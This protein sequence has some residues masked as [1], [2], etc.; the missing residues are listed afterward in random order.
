MSSQS[1]FKFRNTSNTVGSRTL[2]GEDYEWFEWTIYMDEPKEKLDLVDAVEYRLHRTFPNPIRVVKDRDSK[3]AL[4]SSG[5]GMFTI[6]I[7]VYLK[8]GKEVQTQHW[9]Q[10][11]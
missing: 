11:S 10:F 6:Y 3:F 7:T 1:E 8:D 5:W 2:R 4:K 9:L